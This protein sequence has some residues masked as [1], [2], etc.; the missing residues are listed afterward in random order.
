MKKSLL[1]LL[2]AL[3]LLA[4]AQFIGSGRRV[5]PGGGSGTETDPTVSADVKAITSTNISNWNTAFGWGNPSGVY[6]PIAGDVTVSGNKTLSGTTRIASGIFSQNSTASFL[7]TASETNYERLRLQWSSNV[8]FFNTEFGG[9]GTSPRELRLGVA[10]VAGA[11]VARYIRVQPI[12]DC[13]TFNTTG[14]NTGNRFV[15]FNGVSGASSGSNVIVDITGQ[16][17]QGGTAG[18]TQLRVSP[19]L[20]TQGSGAKLLFDVGSNT[21]SDGTG[22]HTSVFNV[23]TDGTI[24]TTGSMLPAVNGTGDIGGSSFKYNNVYT[25]N[26]KGNGTLRLSAGT[27]NSLI[28]SQTVDA[29]TI[30]QFFG[31]TGHLALQAPAALPSDDGTNR[32]QVA[33]SIKATQFRLS[34][35]N[36]APSSA[37]DT[38]TAGEIRITSGFIYYCTATNT[39][40]RVA[41]STW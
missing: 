35:S 1:L 37:T 23:A 30:A 34:A 22:T 21:A 18:H 16:I 36:T 19:F 41:M 40:V 8:M 11:S 5:K 14:I 4:D 2:V 26:V 33:G 15:N 39:W 12:G 28:I 6:V 9:T 27:S 20:Q 10:T 29:N 17:N 7:N 31:T 13:F 3:P 24:T 32:L 38:G 25:N